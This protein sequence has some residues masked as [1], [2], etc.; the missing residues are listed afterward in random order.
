M[1]KRNDIGYWWES[2]EERD[3]HEEL[4]VVWRMILILEK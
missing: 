3:K 4:D 2:R 1:E